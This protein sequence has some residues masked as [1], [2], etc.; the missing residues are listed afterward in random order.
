MITRDSWILMLTIIGAVLGV[1]V[2]QVDLLPLSW[3]AYKGVL[4]I[5][6][7][8]IGVIAGILRSS[9][10]AGINTPQKESYAALGGLVRVSDKVP[11]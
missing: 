3:Q 8:A 1:I 10:L 2:A 5:I 4:T 11:K 6:L 7:S 9:P